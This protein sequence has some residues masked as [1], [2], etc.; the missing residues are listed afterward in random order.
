[1]ERSADSDGSSDGALL[2][3]AAARAARAVVEMLRSAVGGT[4]GAAFC[5]EL[6][7][8][9]DGSSNS[10]PLFAILLV[11]LFCCFYGCTARFC[12]WCRWCRWRR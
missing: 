4:A 2:D 1:M 10:A 12:R 3:D 7:A 11:A 9:S 5:M 8:D 6:S